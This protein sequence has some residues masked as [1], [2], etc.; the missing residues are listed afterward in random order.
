MLEVKALTVAIEKKTI[1]EKLS[2][3]V[4]KG[5][6]A[7]L[8]PNGVGKT[9]LLKALVGINKPLEGQILINKRP[10]KS[11]GELEL[12]QSISLVLQEHRPYFNFTVREM[13]SFGRYPHLGKFKIPTKKDEEMIDSV[14]FEM[15]LNAWEDKF[16]SELSGGEKRLVLI[17][18]SLAQDT[19]IILLDEPTTFLDIK[20]VLCVIAKIKHIAKALNKLVIATMHDINQSLMFSDQ[21]LLLYGAKEFEIGNSSTVINQQNLRRLYG[22]E[23]EILSINNFAH[24]IPKV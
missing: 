11:Y 4:D 7:V 12:A 20:N 18:M 14:I 5:V 19:Q 9:T 1:I 2:F 16:F 10:L 22:V 17:A 6:L 15:G 21:T 24:V 13:I 23:F 3:S 8:G